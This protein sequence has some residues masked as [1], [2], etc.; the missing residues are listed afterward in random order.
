M[1]SRGDDVWVLYPIYFDKS[2]SRKDGRRV[3][4]ELAVDKPQVSE[5]EAVL[6]NADRACGVEKK[7]HPSRWHSKQGRVLVSKSSTKEELIRSVARG[8]KELRK[9]D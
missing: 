8:I 6:T 2:I 9:A 7:R 1:V 5:I 3:S 4:C